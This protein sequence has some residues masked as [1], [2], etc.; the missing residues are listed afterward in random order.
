MRASST[1]NFATGDAFYEKLFDFADGLFVYFRHSIIT[2][3]QFLPAYRRQLRAYR[4]MCPVLPLQDGV[5][6]AFCNTEPFRNVAWRLSG[7]SQI[8]NFLHLAFG[9]F[10]REVSFALF[11]MSQYLDCMSVILK[12]CCPFKIRGMVMGF[13][14]VLVIHLNSFLRRRLQKGFCRK[15]MN[16]NR[17]HLIAAL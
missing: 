10:C 11:V 17:L 2:A 8:E 5:D 12:R 16:V 4:E 13:I 15:A 7:Y 1:G 6:A 14:S 9:K 3:F